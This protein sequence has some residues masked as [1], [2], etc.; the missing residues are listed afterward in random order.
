MRARMK[1]PL[2]RTAN[3][4]L[5]V[6]KDAESWGQ[7]DDEY[8]HVHSDY[9]RKAAERLEKQGQDRERTRMNAD[10]DARNPATPAADAMV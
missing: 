10:S 7:V 4:S 8:C 5:C 2:C 9:F 3:L 1:S 6:Q